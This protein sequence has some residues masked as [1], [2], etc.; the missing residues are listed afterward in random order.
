MVLDNWME[1]ASHRKHNDCIAFCMVN[2]EL[3]RIVATQ[4]EKALNVSIIELL[5]V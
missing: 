1:R 5:E 4:N 3:C 2:R